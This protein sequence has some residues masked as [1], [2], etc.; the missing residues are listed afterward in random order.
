MNRYFFKCNPS[1][2]VYNAEG[3]CTIHAYQKFYLEKGII[4]SMA[5]VTAHLSE[6]PL[7]VI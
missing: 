7:G 2:S 6:G 1:T 4:D 3:S 5:F